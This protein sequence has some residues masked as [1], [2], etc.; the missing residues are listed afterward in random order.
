MNDLAMNIKALR[1]YQNI[2]Q[3]E[4][5]TRLGVSQTSIAHY[6][7]GDRQPTIETLISLSD[8]FGVSIDELVGHKKD[9]KT[10]SGLLD[11]DRLI[12]E[13]YEQLKTKKTGDFVERMEAVYK[14]FDEETILEEVIAKV[15]ERI[16]RGWE[17]GII[18]EADEHYATNTVRKS[19][20]ILSL[21]QPATLKT[22]RAISFAVHSEQ[23]TL[24]V[25]LVSALLEKKGIETL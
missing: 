11:K 4:L 17:M 23:H 10:D 24:G 8:I 18:S 5:A 1:S 7:K 6:E 9:I 16:G 20:N 22:K 14:A 15:L 13:L 12:D 3:V 19:M 21:K 2:S 25:E